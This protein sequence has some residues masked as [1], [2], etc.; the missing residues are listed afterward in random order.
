[1]TQQL[2][3]C[4]IF[5]KESGATR[6]EGCATEDGEQQS[7]KGGFITIRNTFPDT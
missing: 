1:M 4:V 6:G 3:K 7:A 2:V 5:L